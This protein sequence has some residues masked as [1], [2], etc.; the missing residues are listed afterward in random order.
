M[1]CKMYSGQDMLFDKEDKQP[2]NTT[3]AGTAVQRI[4]TGHSPNHTVRQV[5]HSWT[6][7]K[8]IIRYENDD[9]DPNDSNTNIFFKCSNDYQNKPKEDEFSP[10][11]LKHIYRLIIKMVWMQITR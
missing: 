7:F 5:R 2:G 11:Y 10:V 1:K 6:L 3:G 8:W 9:D 4:P